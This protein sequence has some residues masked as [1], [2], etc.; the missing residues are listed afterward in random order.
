MLPLIVK[1]W[2]PKAYIA[3]FKLETDASL[4]IPKSKRALEV[5]GHQ[6]VIG[7]LLNTRKFEIIF[8]FPNGGSKLV[9]LTEEE[10]KAELDI[11]TIIV[12]E[13]ITYH[14]HWIAS[15]F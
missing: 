1:E 9:R 8:I 11:E 2:A 15:Q 6:V 5:Y 12:C 3:S 4:L 14:N 13:L 7:N 10:I